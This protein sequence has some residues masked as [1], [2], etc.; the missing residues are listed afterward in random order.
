MAGEKRSPAPIRGLRSWR[1]LIAFVG[2]AAAIVAYEGLATGERYGARNGLLV[3]A[4]P[5]AM[6]IL[7]VGVAYGSWIMR[8]LR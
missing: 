4:L 2:V 3:Y 6:A 8:K 7:A 1:L 5:A